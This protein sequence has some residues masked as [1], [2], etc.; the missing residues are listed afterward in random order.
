MI[1]TIRQATNI[2]VN[3]GDT[4]YLFVKRKHGFKVLSQFYKNKELVFESSLYTIFL[5][6]KVE[7][8]FQNLPHFISFE[9]EKG[10][11]Y[12]LHYDDTI[13]SIKV[14]YFK[15]PAFRLFQNDVQVGIIGNPKLVVFESRYYQMET[16][17]N[18]EPTNLYFL[19]LF[20]S[21]LRAT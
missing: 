5:K 16:T 12:S 4:Q 10:W 14:K 21:Q 8:K 17:T 3:K 7:I 6:Q 13:L 19:I 20:L 2:T 11:Y 18:D 1:L 15:R 9:R